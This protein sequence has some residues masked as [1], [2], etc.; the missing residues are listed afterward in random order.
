MSKKRIARVI[1]NTLFY[2]A[3]L[4]ILI[5]GLTWGVANGEAKSL[6]GY[7]IFD[8]LTDS[9]HSEIP[10]GSLVVVKQVETD[11]L[12]T[13][14]DITFFVDND[15]TYTHRITGIYENYEGSG[16]RGFE[17]KGINN[18]MPDKDIV[19]AGNVVGKM[20]FHA[21]VAG[22]LLAWVKIRWWVCLLIFGGIALAAYALKILSE[23]EN[24]PQG[25]RTNT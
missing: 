5:A 9:M 17:T 2:G 23:K 21:A 25:K 22:Q 20:V 13:G 14:D 6:F 1:G 16:M 19:Y 4:F 11:T 7:S 15:T 12:K 3:L 8:V 24:P 10:R 18:P